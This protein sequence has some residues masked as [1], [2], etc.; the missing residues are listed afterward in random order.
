MPLAVVNKGT[1]IYMQALGRALESTVLSLL[2][3]IVLGVLLPLLLPLLFAL[4]GVIYSF[5]VADL[6]T[7]A[8]T[9]VLIAG[10][11]RRLG[12]SNAAERL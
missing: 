11:Y 7:F 3:E 8:V 1:F 2:R 5:P 10:T 4:D 9:L 12:G 6:V